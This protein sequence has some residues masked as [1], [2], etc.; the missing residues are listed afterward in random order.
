MQ[1]PQAG[2]FT[3][4]VEFFRKQRRAAIAEKG[5]LVAFMAVM[6][7]GCRIPGQP[8]PLVQFFFHGND[9]VLEG[10]GHAASLL[11]FSQV[12]PSSHYLI[13]IMWRTES[14]NLFA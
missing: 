14:N 3:Q 1:Q 7:D 9:S 8:I 11:W 10:I 5:G 6:R 4:Q 12:P 2:D 13:E